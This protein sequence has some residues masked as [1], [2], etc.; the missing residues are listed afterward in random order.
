MNYFLEEFSLVINVQLKKYVHW[1][2]LIVVKL[3]VV[4]KTAKN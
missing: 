1:L 3:D 2:D 4:A